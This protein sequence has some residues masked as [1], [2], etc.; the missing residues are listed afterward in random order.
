MG[1]ARRRKAAAADRDALID[2]DRLLGNEGAQRLAYR[3]RCDGAPRRSPGCER[4]QLGLACPRTELV[5]KPLQGMKRVLLG[6]REHAKGRII[7]REQ[8][9][10][11]GICEKAYGD[12]RADEDDVLQPAQGFDRCL[13][14]IGK[15]LEGNAPRPSL[16]ACVEGLGHEPGARFARNPAGE[17][18]AARAHGST[19]Q[20]Q[21][22]RLTRAQGRSRVPNGV[23]GHLAPCRDV[24]DSARAVGFVPGGIARQNESCDLSRRAPCS[25]NRS[26]AIRGDGARVGR[27]AHPP[28]ERPRRRL[29][30]GGERR[31]VSP[32]IGRVVTDDVHDR[33]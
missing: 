29:D 1:I 27:G 25:R 18:E 33:R 11:V 30:V 7:R 9:W 2:N 14:R 10:L 17:L 31:V 3:Q 19:R 5:R 20:Q 22:S 12:F 23:G 26:G 13:D 24:R 32:M 6:P 16:H 4:R 15:A 21:Q 8:A 28:R